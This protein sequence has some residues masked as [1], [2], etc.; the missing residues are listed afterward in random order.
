MLLTACLKNAS[1]HIRFQ[2]Q[3]QSQS[4]WLCGCKW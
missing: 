4:S 1:N 3:Q 2:L